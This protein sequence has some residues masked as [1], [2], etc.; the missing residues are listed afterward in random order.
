M[1][2]G[3]TL[4]TDRESVLERNALRDQ[5]TVQRRGQKLD[6]S[7]GFQRDVGEPLTRRKQDHQI[8]NAPVAREDV[9][10]AHTKQRKKN[11]NKDLET[12]LRGHKTSQAR[13]SEY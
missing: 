8:A 6:M 9:R 3:A 4:S 12:G 2:K 5:F 11:R 7:C 10:F 13:E 1:I